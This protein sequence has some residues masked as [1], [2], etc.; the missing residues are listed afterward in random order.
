MKILL[1]AYGSRGDVQP[2]LALAAALNR[3]GHEATL[4]APAMHEPF[5]AEHGVV[6]FPRNDAPLRWLDLPETRELFYR[7]AAA[8]SGTMTKAE[9]KEHK[10]L[11]KRYLSIVGPELDALAVPMLDE[12]LQAAVDVRPDVL[13]QT[14]AG[15]DYSHFVAEKHG[16]PHLLADLYPNYVPSSFYPSPRYHDRTFPKALNRLTH[17]V[18]SRRVPMRKKVDRWRQDT[19]GL[20][21]RRHRF[22]RLLTYAGD[23]VHVLHMF[24]R[25]LFPPAPDWP[26]S[27]H[28]MGFSYLS[29]DGY[30][31]PAELSRFLGAGARPVVIGFG[32]LGNP[33]PVE[34][35][36]MV[37]QAVQAAGVRAVVIRGA[38]QGIQLDDHGDNMIVVDNVPFAWLLPRARGIVHGGGIGVTHDAL[39]A[40]LP[41]QACPQYREPKMW[42]DRVRHTGAGL[43]PI[44]QS[45]LTVDDL[46]AALRRLANDDDLYAA[47]QLMRG[48]IRS[49]PG[50]PMAVDLIERTVASTLRA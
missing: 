2:Y 24:S 38:G 5:A 43:D 27:V 48:R 3:A 12:Q 22:D 45:A 18:A 11:S 47:A 25:F 31:P 30:R 34:R 29:A 7:E 44:W 19:L 14:F 39:A 36:R 33:H 50:H 1:F 21:P 20:S 4:A 15:Q 16:V 28:N 10:E 26:A 9:R 17:L 32:S 49:E 8:V 13:V 41:S 23:P 37:S 42:A 46:T 35:G 40:G 6:L